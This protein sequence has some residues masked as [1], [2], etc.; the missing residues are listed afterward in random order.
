MVVHHFF[1]FRSYLLPDV[2]WTSLLGIDAVAASR[3]INIKITKST[4]SHAFQNT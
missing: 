2:S 4:S 1:G 3:M